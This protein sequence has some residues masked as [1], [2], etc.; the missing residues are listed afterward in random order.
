MGKKVS[1][2]EHKP[3]PKAG[4]KTILNKMQTRD[5]TVRLFGEL[6]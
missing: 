4:N 6:T 5:V 2:C 1:F 3:L